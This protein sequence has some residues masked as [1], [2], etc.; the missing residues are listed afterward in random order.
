MRTAAVTAVIAAL[1]VLY[2]LFR[3]H[4]W[5]MTNW[6]LLRLARFLLGEAH[7]GRP[8]TDAGWFR[9]GV[10]AL[11]PTGH[12]TRWWHRP[13]WQRAAHRTGGLAAVV[14]VAWGFIVSPLVTS[15]AA[16]ALLS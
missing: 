1:I 16:A 5:L 7:H 12:A 2:L 3:F 10:K 8:V 11:T 13:K 15:V 4:R 6:F 14:A 9:P